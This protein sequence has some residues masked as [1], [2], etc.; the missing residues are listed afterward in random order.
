MNAFLSDL[1]KSVRIVE[2]GPRDGL[3]NQPQKIDTALKSE[4][5]RRLAACGL[6]E[7]E[8]TSFVRPDWIPQLADATDVIAALPTDS[9]TLF[10]A[11]VPN[12]RGLHTARDAGVKRIA[13]FT[14]ASET[15]NKKNTNASIEESLE[16]FRGIFDVLAGQ[17]MFVRGYVSTAFGCPYEGDVAVEKVVEVSRALHELGCQELSISDTI[18]VAHPRQVTEVVDAVAAVVPREAI[19]LHFHD[20]RGLALNNVV[21][22]LHVGVTTYDAS[23]GGLGG[24]PYAPGAAGNLATEDLVYL[25]DGLGIESGVDLDA[26]AAAN[27]WFESHF[28]QP[29]PSRVL[30]TYRSPATGA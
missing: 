14:A 27:L 28:E 30:A 26:L 4:W 3:Q 20:T 19:A 15:F 24:C 9:S 12:L 8:A 5:I 6:P 11:L 16:R 17:E 1:P 22:G 7:V 2:V 21:A 29:F 23:A 13:L 10:S 18:G 25:L